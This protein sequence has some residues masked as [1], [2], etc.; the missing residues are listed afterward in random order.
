MIR[1]F[2]EER[3]WARFHL[4]R[5]LLLA[6]MGE[7]GELAELVQWKKDE[8]Q[9]MDQQLLD[10]MGQEVADVTIYLLRLADVCGVQLQVNRE[11]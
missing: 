11:E 2:A 10:K 7:L 8:H 3:K 1:E 5:S 6:L 9:T 4:P